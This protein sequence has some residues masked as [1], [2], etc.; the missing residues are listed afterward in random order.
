LIDLYRDAWTRAGHPPEGLKVGINTFGFVGETTQEAKEGFF[1]GWQHVFAS[2]A[3]ERGWSPPSRDQ[4]EAM[5]G[6]G[7]V[8]LIG[9]PQTVAAK[10]IE[11]NDVLGGLSR[12]SFQLGVAL[13]PHETMKR[14]IQLLGTEVGPT[15]RQATAA[16]RISPAEPRVAG[17]K[18]THV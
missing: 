13:L 5:C 15:V 17:P 14:A 16:D 18:G 9:D 10:A 2:S 11:A 1:P 3:V 12:I 7:G 6:P 4:F 8:F